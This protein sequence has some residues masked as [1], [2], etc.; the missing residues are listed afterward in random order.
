MCYL[1]IRLAELYCLHSALSNLLGFLPYH[2]LK[3]FLF[4]SRFCKC[5]ITVSYSELVRSL[6][7]AGEID[8]ETDAILLSNSVDCSDFTPQ[9]SGGQVGVFV[10]NDTYI[11]CTCYIA[12]RSDQVEMCV[13]IY[14]GGKHSN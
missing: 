4:N 1:N 11:I 7:E 13:V 14:N 8:P 3:L 2:S 10:D 12:I 6:G 5:V 9:V